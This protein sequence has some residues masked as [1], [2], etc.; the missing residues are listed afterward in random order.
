M[1]LTYKEKVN[2][3]FELISNDDLHTVDNFIYE[4]FHPLELA[5]WKTIS[6]RIDLPVALFMFYHILIHFEELSDLE[7]FSEMNE[8]RP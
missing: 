3:F 1:I 8:D 7:Y 4:N 6:V 2:K 5:I